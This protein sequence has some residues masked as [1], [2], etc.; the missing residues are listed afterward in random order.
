[1]KTTVDIDEQQ[2]V[3]NNAYWVEFNPEM[4]MLGKWTTVHLEFFPYF[5]LFLAVI[6][7]SI[8]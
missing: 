2:K 8:S 4:E 6:N 1:M 3:T 7:Y 5:L